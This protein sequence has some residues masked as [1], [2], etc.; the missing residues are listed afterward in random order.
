MQVMPFRRYH[1]NNLNGKQKHAGMNAEQG[2]FCDVNGIN[3]FN[4]PQEN[5]RI[6]VWNFCVGQTVFPWNVAD[7]TVNRQFK[8]P[9]V[10]PL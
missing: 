2:M 7:L 9:V 3:K 1:H 8:H 4:S 5:D 10:Y 6:K